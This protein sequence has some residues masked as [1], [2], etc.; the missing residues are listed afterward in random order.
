M[1]PDLAER[2]GE[3]GAPR[4]DPCGREIDLRRLERTAEKEQQVGE[5]QGEA[6]VVRIEPEPFPVRAFG[7]GPLVSSARHVGDRQVGERR[8]RVGFDRRLGREPCVVDSEDRQLAPRQH[9]KCP[10]AGRIQSGRLRRLSESG[11]VPVTIQEYGGHQ[12]MR[13]RLVWLEAESGLHGL[14]GC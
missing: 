1:P 6:L 3:R 12:A 9:A 8:L 4:I 13:P 11:G 10:Y 5:A 14:T 7:L 2:L